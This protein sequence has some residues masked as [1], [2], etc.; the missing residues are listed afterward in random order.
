MRLEPRYLAG[1]AY[2]R[3]RIARA[4]LRPDAGRWAGVRILGYHRVADVDDVLAVRP[5]AF[6]RQLEAVLESGARPISLADAVTLLERPVE[7]RHVV[8]TFDD[9]YRD[10]LEAAVPLLEELGIPATIFVPTS[11]IDGTAPYYW[12]ADPPPALSWDELRALDAGG[13]VGVEA[14]TRTHPHLPKVDEERAREEIVEGRRELEA[15]LGRPVS[16]FCYPAGLYGPR[17]VALVAEAGYRVGLTTDPGVNQGRDDL[18]TLR[19]TLLYVG[20]S[21]ADFAAKLD[22]LLDAPSALRERLQRRRSAASS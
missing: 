19:R 8:V 13:L 16:A 1:R 10:N 22:G 18:L 17:D 12:Y 3:A 5:D 20:D 6:R 14:H 11:V 15:R 9:G 21:D 4:R 2:Q 7:G